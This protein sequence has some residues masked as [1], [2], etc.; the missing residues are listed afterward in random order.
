MNSVEWIVGGETAILDTEELIHAALSGRVIVRTSDGVLHTA[1]RAR[2]L[3]LTVVPT[4]WDREHKADLLRRAQRAGL[5]G[6]AAC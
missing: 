5:A 4:Q 2:E 1:P 3:G 6:G